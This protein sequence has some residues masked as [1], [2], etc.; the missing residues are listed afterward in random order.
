[1]KNVDIVEVMR[2]LIVGCGHMGAAH[3]RAYHGL[4]GVSIAGVVAR[5]PGA[6]ESLA[7]EL[8]GPPVFD[9]LEAGLA[10][11]PDAVCI[12]T[13]PD[14][15]AALCLASFR[16]GAHVFVEKPLAPTL[17]E[18]AAVVT[19][20]REH[21]RVLVVGY[22]LRHHPA[23]IR[24]IELARALGK[25]LVVRISQ[26]QQSHGAHWE[27]HLRLMQSVSPLVDC[28]VHYVDVMGQMTQAR[29]LRVQAMGAR[30]ADGL[31]AGRLNY[32]QLQVRY[33]DGSVGWYEAGWGPMMSDE[34][35]FIK[36]VVG[37]R[38]S[39]TMRAEGFRLHHAALAANGGLARPDETLP[40]P[41][42]PTLVELCRREQESFLQAIADG[43]DLAEH[44][45]ASLR[46][47]QIVLA[48]DLSIRE[49]RTIE[50]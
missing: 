5:R 16:A 19:A 33:D 10:G 35:H 47:L 27:G 44:H 11:R 18:A 22:I 4:P 43:R 2:V 42:D 50:I 30:L 1:L 15:H 14:S 48:A 38:G 9:S 20:A 17:E 7:A 21:R 41:A 49:G 36:D 46:S 34:A 8:G 32:G 23:W 24:F 6:R 29:A 31:P 3:A 26:N 12:S 25:P 37:P 40:R 28:G 13:P 39:L 45:Q